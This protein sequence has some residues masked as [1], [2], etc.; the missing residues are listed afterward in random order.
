MISNLIVFSTLFLGVLFTVLYIVRPEFRARVEQPKYA[1]LE[2]LS[3]YDKSTG[4]GQHG[5][6]SEIPVGKSSENKSESDSK[7]KSAARTK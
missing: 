2:Q 5:G 4:V 6:E 3:I 1:F 7:T